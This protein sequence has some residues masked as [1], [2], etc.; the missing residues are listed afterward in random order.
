MAPFDRLY[1][2]FYWSAIVTI[3]LSH[4]IFELFDLNNIV[5]LKSGLQVTRS[6]KMVPF[7]SLGA[8]FCSPSIVTIVL[9]CIICEK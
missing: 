9:S 3:D 6:F 7:K 2:T 8:L 5:T 1:M 4:T